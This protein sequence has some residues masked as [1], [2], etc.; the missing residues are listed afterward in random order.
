MKK[1]KIIKYIILTLCV[2]TFIGLFLPYANATGEKLEYFKENQEETFVGYK[3]YQIK[4]KEMISISVA[5]FF[6]NYIYGIKIAKELEKTL[7]ME[8]KGSTDDLEI[9]AITIGVSVISL[10]LLGIFI[11]LDKRKGIRFLSI[12]LFLSSGFYNLYQKSSGYLATDDYGAGIGYHIL[13]YAPLLIILILIFKKILSKFDKEVKEA[14]EKEKTKKINEAEKAAKKAKREE[15][16]TNIK[17]YL[18]KLSIFDKE[19][20]EPL[21]KGKTKK[22]NEAEKAAK[23]AKREETLTNIKKYLKI[24]V[25]IIV[26]IIL[27]SLVVIWLKGILTKEKKPEPVEEVRSNGPTTKKPDNTTEVIENTSFTNTSNN[28]EYRIVKV[29]NNPIII[30]T[31]KNEEIVNIHILVQFFDEEDKST[32]ARTITYKSVPTGFEFASV[33]EGAPTDYKYF[34]AYVDVRSS[35]EKDYVSGINITPIDKDNS[36]EVKIYNPEVSYYN[37]STCITIVYYNENDPIK[38][39][40]QCGKFEKNSKETTVS[41]N[42]PDSSYTTYKLYKYYEK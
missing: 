22:I 42:K 5:E 20:K 11:Y 19:V 38:I 2:I 41:F 34:K 7:D 6:R 13:K 14:L 37:Y 36:I 30:G 33:L 29:D 8:L 16:L 18:K 26:I 24:I 10:A 12:I 15:T 9:L 40:K 1:L 17:K 27:L 3:K 25:K 32:S 39:D 21:E 23:K 4:N 35:R 28:V 31:N